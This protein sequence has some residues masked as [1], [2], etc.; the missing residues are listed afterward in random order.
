[1]IEEGKPKNQFLAILKKDIKL[2][3]APKSILT[4]SAGPFVMIF[5]ITII[6]NMISGTIEMQINIGSMDSGAIVQH[7]NGTDYSINLGNVAIKAIR[8][9]YNSNPNIQ[10]SVV[11]TR[12]E[13][14]NSSAGI[15][16]PAN[17]TTITFSGQEPVYEYHLSYSSASIQASFFNVVFRKVQETIEEYFLFLNLASQMPTIDPKVYIPSTIESEID[18][19]SEATYN[20]AQPYAYAI[21]LFGSI[22]VGIGKTIGFS[23]EREDGTFETMLTITRRRSHLVLSKLVVGIIST[24]IIIISYLAGAIMGGL[25]SLGKEGGS[26]ISIIIF[27]LQTVLSWKGILL[28]M[29]TTLSLT[30]TLVL[31]ITFETLFSKQ[32]ADMLGIFIVIGL[33]FLF[34]FPIIINPRTSLFILHINPYYWIY[35]ITLSIINTSFSWIDALYLVLFGAALTGLVLTATRAI[36]KE[37]LLFT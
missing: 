26:L 35:H 22:S 28:I 3:M 19:W 32:V 14:L 10:V 20:L 15:W 37:N 24:F 4:M 18:G 6:P 31:L 8:E 9:Y 30:L 12:G 13:A 1:M 25:P 2:L 5:L 36:N 23:K 16:F 33:G 11:S 27:D 21:L 29:S 34:F 7:V 17:F